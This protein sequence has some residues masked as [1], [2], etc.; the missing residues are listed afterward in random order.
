MTTK[1][2]RAEYQ[3]DTGEYTP[4][5]DDFTVDLL[6]CNEQYDLIKYIQWVE[7]RTIKLENKFDEI[8]K[9]LKRL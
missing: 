2:L 9:L 8:T 5:P 1:D 7:E 4:N 6:D 3:R